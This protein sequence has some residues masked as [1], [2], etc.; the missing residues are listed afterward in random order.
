MRTPLAVSLLDRSRTR[1]GSGDADAVRA[2]VGRARRAEAT[3]FDRFWVA[4]HHAVPGVVGSAPAVL[5]AA[6]AAAT[7]SVRVG[8]GGVMLPNHAAFVVAE[9]FAVLQALHPGRVDLGVGRSLGFTAPVRRALER[10]APE[11]GDFEGQLG[12]L[13]DHLHGRGGVTVRPAVPAPPVFLLATRSGLVTAARL[14]L[15][16][17]VGG[18]ALEDPR[19]LDAYR[20]GFRARPDD[21]DARPRVTVAVD[22]LVADSAAQARRRL[23]PQAWSLA[24]A[25]SRGEFPPLPTDDEADRAPLTARERRTAEEALAG[26]VH[27]T[28]ATVTDALERLVRRT[29]ASEL[30]V[31]T[32]VHDEDV[33]A[34]ADE[35]LL[36]LVTGP[37]AARLRTA[38]D[39]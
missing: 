37:L 16:V 31:A 22:V 27:G 26:T 30:L 39:G 14:G 6:V 38:D 2:T 17:V 32:T 5:L 20:R 34:A 33:Q 12:D 19:L 18:P 4:E 35:A 24:V 9:Q 1:T 25:R 3:G 10:P 7:S 29:G 13:L 23:L 36:D 11:A 21:P 15:P 28:A 8:S